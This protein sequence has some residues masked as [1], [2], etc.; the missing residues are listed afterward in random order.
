MLLHNIATWLYKLENAYDHCCVIYFREFNIIHADNPDLPNGA[1]G[2][3]QD[4]DATKAIVIL[5]WNPPE[6]HN[7]TAIDYY[8]LTLIGI[9]FNTTTVVYVGEDTQQFFSHRLVVSGGNLIYTAASIMAVDVCGQRSEPS[10]FALTTIVT[11]TS[12]FPTSNNSTILYYTLIALPWT[13][14]TL[15]CCVKLLQCCCK[16]IDT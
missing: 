10:H 15:V 8:E 14:S 16:Y 4:V 13:I 3:I 5:N 12:T 9:H 6:N 2:S 11:G 7:H 1:R